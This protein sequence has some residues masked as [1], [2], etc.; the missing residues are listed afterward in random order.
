MNKDIIDAEFSTEA[1]LMPMELIKV[2]QVPEV[3]FDK[4]KQ[5]NAQIIAKIESLNLKEMVANEENLREIKAV[6]AEMNKDLKAL[7]ESRKFTERTILAPYKKFEKEYNE[8][9]KVPLTETV[10]LLKTKVD[11]VEDDMRKEKT[12]KYEDLFEENKTKYKLDFLKFEDLGLNIQISTADSK[13]EKELEDFFKKINDDIA[14]INTKSAAERIQIEYI[15]TLDLAAS[16]LKV[17]EAM[18]LEEQLKLRREA[19]AKRAEEERKQREIEA[20]ARKEYMARVEKENAELEKK[21]KQYKEEAKSAAEDILRE[22]Y[23]K[24]KEAVE[25]KKIQ[26]KMQAEA[27]AKEKEVVTINIKITGTRSQFKN[28]KAFMMK[29]GLT[30][31]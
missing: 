5:F 25:L 9:I 4:L 19:E 23:A 12:K 17:E 3:E 7:E 20:A 16:I 30:Y 26:A 22:E 2:T 14:I 24:Q 8:L 1:E 29:E 31:E 11:T 10:K 18:K 27:A 21:A 28:F 13:L 6:R 15:K